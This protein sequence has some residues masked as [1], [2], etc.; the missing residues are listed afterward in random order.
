MK[1]FRAYPIELAKACAN[2][3]VLF[4]APTCH[5]LAI[6]GSVRREKIV[7]HD[8]DL[9]AWARYPEQL[10]PT[11]FD[12]PALLPSGPE[13]LTQAIR[14]MDLSFHDT[15]PDAKILRFSYY[16]IPVEIYL[17]ERDGRNFCALHQMRTGSEEH[18]KRLA[19]TALASG[20]EYHAGY[21]I[22]RP[23]GQRVDDGTEA[24]IYQALGLHFFE[25]EHRF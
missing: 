9:V 21:G 7:V 25:P 8:I 13:A 23:D 20:L 10:A 5:Q 11:L 12:G 3:L 24:G 22:F 18:N 6:A 16:E 2:D 15:R 19:A 1:K 4:L 14:R 17:T